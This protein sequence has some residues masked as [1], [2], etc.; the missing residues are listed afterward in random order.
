LEHSGIPQDMGFFNCERLTGTGETGGDYKRL[1]DAIGALNF[2]RLDD[3]KP[4]NHPI[5][6]HRSPF[7][8]IV[9]KKIPS[10]LNALIKDLTNIRERLEHVPTLI[11]DDESDQAGVNTKK[12]TAKEI[13]ERLGL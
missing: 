3:T 10:R 7:R 9:I 6:L 2:Q 1:R 5:N 13:K 12:P 8:L 4:F 11:I